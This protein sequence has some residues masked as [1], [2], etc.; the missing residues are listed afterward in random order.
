MHLPSSARVLLTTRCLIL[1]LHGVLKNPTNP[2]RAD[3]SP[4]LVK[5]QVHRIPTGVHLGDKIE[6]KF[7]QQEVSVLPREVVVQEKLNLGR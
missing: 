1:E 6:R 7:L 2:H 3:R 5:V 4:G